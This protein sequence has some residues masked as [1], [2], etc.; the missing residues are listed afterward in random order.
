M[1]REPLAVV[2][3]DVVAQCRIGCVCVERGNGER[4]AERVQGSCSWVP[5][6]GTRL[7][8][9]TAA[10]HL[11]DPALVLVA[12][13]EL[14]QPAKRFPGR[15]AKW[16]ADAHGIGQAQ[17]VVDVF[18]AQRSRECHV[19]AEVAGDHA[20]RVA[21]DL[22]ARGLARDDGVDDLAQVEACALGERQPLG[23]RGDLHAA[24]Q[25]IT[26]L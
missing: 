5:P 25:L 6:S 3:R 24:D 17:G 2:G 22:R 16:R 8:V 9:T 4:G 21:H 7:Y 15:G 13:A 18:E 1:G 11:D 14:E 10:R 19:A 26:S 12:A 20:L 23:G